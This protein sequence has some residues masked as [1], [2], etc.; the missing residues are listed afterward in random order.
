MRLT[1]SG[2][3]LCPVAS[4]KC[5]SILLHVTHVLGNAV[6]GCGIAAAVVLVLLVLTS[7]VSTV[8]SLLSP[9]SNSYRY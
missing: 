9:K 1:V 8:G 4:P 7:L 5:Q 2:N 6:L 3:F